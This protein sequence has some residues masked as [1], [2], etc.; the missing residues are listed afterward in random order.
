MINII[1]PLPCVSCPIP[2][3]SSVPPAGVCAHSLVHVY[4]FLQLHMGIEPILGFV[5]VT[6]KSVNSKCEIYK[7]HT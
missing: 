4:C 3:G 2:V 6:P 7:L 1:R 5:G